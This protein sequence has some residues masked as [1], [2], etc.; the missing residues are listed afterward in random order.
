M[1]TARCSLRE[2]ALPILT[3]Y[4]PCLLRHYLLLYL[5]SK[6]P[7]RRLIGSED[8]G[9]TVEEVDAE[10]VEIKA[11]MC[12]RVRM[13][14][15]LTKSDGGT[16]HDRRTA[17]TLRAGSASG[18]PTDLRAADLRTTHLLIHRMPLAVAALAATAPT[19][20]LCAGTGSLS[21]PSTTTTA[22]RARWARW[23]TPVSSWGC[24]SGS[25]FF[26]TVVSSTTSRGP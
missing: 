13:P 12:R 20:L 6:E 4:Q 9:K 15:L 14:T 16:H 8:S 26:A 24:R 11:V 23:P 1:L 5:L 2:G 25:P 7:F 21:T 22:E 17:R 19:N 10:I 3:N 18:P